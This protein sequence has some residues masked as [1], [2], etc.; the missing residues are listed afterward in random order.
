M[1][2]LPTDAVPA[3]KF[4]LRRH[5]RPIDV[6]AGSRYFAVAETKD[7]RADDWFWNDDNAKVLE[8]LSRPEVWRQFREETTEILRFVR[9]MCRG[10]FIFR[11]V[12]AP[13]LDLVGSKDGIA[14]YRHSL[15]SL[16][17]VPAQNAVIA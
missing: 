9:S 14:S 10:P 13:R 12:S 16:R 6:T 7:R 4:L 15:M 2:S 5:Y 3:A 8:L 17:H 1:P 11:R